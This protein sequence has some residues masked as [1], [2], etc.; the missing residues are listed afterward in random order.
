MTPLAKNHLQADRKMN[1]VRTAVIGTG[2]LGKY[3]V[4]KYAELPNSELIAVC[5]VNYEQGRVIADAY[6]TEAIID[7]KTLI[8]RV[9]AV[10]IVTPTDLHFDIAL[11]FLENGV[12]VL[13]EKPITTTTDEADILINTAKTHNVLLQVGHLERF[14]NAV[15]EVRPSLSN[16]RFIES[17]RLAP[18]KLRGIEVSVI[19][20]LMIHDIDI[21][22]S[23]VNSDIQRIAANGASVL[24]PF[25]DI[26]N[27]RLEFANGCVANVTASR[28]SRKVERKL[29]IFQH[30]GYIGMDLDAK[31]IWSHRK[32]PGEMF[33]GIPEIISEEHS[34]DKGDALKEQIIS[35]LDCIEHN[36]APIVDG[37]AGKKALATA[38]EITNIVNKS[39]AR[40]PLSELK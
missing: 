24:S 8:G 7:Y 2:Y 33:P 29:R 3:H 26:A 31:K 17:S 1:K 4:E 34:F 37:V 36:K 10:S 5:D 20:D 16:P 18:F 15:K 35:Y 19:L 11:F 21:I 12:H 32:G 25:I 13:V 9:D 14:N 22:Q 38:I 6:D 39:N 27:A 40:F 23:I 28:V 30:D